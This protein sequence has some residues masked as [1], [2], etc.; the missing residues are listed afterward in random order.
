MSSTA[1]SWSGWRESVARIANNY[2]RASLGQVKAEQKGVVGDSGLYMV[3]VSQNRGKINVV[4]GVQRVLL[5]LAVRVSG[6]VPGVHYPCPEGASRTL[7]ACCG[8]FL[9]RAAVQERGPNVW[10]SWF[11]GDTKFTLYLLSL[12]GKTEDCNWPPNQDRSW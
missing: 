1:G 3:A 10:G 8:G 12:A 9:G 2:A 11:Q 6:K 4:H 7:V 5:A